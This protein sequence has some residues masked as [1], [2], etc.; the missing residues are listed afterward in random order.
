MITICSMAITGLF[1]MVVATVLSCANPKEAADNSLMG[2]YQIS[3]IIEN[4]NREHPERAWSQVQK[5]NPLTEDLKEKI[6]QIDGIDSI[7]CYLGNCVESDAFDGDR[8]WMLG[9]P[10]SE[11]ELLEN[12]I[13]EGSITYEELKSG[14]KVVID[15][16][17]LH[18][19]PNL[20][21]GDVID[22]V[23]WDGDV[24]CQ[25][26][27]EIAAI[28]DY[29]LGFTRY[30]Y[31]IMAD[32]GLRSFSENNLNMY[33]RMFA[34]QKYDADVEAKLGTIVEENGRIQMETWK[35]YYD[36]WK[37]ALTLTRGACYAFL[38]ILGAICIMN[39]INT[40]IHSV[41]VRKKEIGMLQ[42]VGMSDLQLLKMLQ[43]EGLFYTAGTLVIAAG[44]GSIAGYPVFLWAKNHGMFS[45]RNYHYPLAATL[46]M[47]ALLVMVQVIMVFVIGK[48]VKKDSLIDRIR[49]DN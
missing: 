38:G 4:D 17:L 6:L 32:E 34:S 27:L 29:D 11:K 42:A 2:E 37:S 3:P 26:P 20:K 41:H 22:A 31:L 18:F 7:E 10:E 14:K 24:K 13:I 49:F 35:S 12:G 46:I 1:F 45:I 39:M 47:S 48:S 23:T 19:Y 25:K 5:N 9:V 15:K 40:M 16:N 43:L 8:E 30:S 44:G 28:G 21:I 33:Y 36:E